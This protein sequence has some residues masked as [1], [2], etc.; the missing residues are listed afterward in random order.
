MSG[1][2]ADDPAFDIRPAA[3]RSLIGVRTSLGRKSKRK[4]LSDP[5]GSRT[6]EDT[7]RHGQ[8]LQRKAD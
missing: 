3:P 4:G 8:I 6:L 7:N 2:A 5:F 1:G